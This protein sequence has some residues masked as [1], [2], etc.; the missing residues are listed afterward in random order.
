MQNRLRSSYKL[1]ADSTHGAMSPVGESFRKSIALNP[2]LELYMQDQ[3][4]P[5]LEGSYLAACTFYEVLFQKSVLSNTYTA[6]ITTAS[7]VPFLQQVAH[8]VVNDS[9]N[10]WNLGGKRNLGLILRKH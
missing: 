9:L 3:S 4:H 2:S 8:T 1:F 7:V 10:V 5:A 6:G